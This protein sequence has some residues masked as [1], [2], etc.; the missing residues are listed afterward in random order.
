MV[1]LGR[2]VFDFWL[3]VAWTLIKF[4]KASAYMYIPNNAHL[5][6]SENGIFTKS[7]RWAVIMQIKASPP[8]CIQV[9]GQF[10]N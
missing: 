8:F 6:S 7:L 10:K 9:A 3:L 4:C 5:L 2:N 1:S